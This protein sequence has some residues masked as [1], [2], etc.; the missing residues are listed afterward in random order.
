[1]PKFYFLY[2]KNL[3]DI[4]FKNFFDE[5]NHLFK[6]VDGQ[7]VL[8]KDISSSK[9]SRTFKNSILKSLSV[10][11]IKYD[12]LKPTYYIILGSC[13]PKD[14]LL[15]KC[16]NDKC[17][18]EKLN[19]VINADFQVKYLLKEKDIKLDLVKFNNVCCDLFEWF[20]KSNSFSKM[21]EFKNVLF[22]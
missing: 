9:L 20:F 13:M 21:P 1:M 14:N 8:A 5:N 19:K 18:P 16:K 2:F 4:A 17:F 6:N 22:V 11:I 15:L 12:R 10:N 3:L 7:Y